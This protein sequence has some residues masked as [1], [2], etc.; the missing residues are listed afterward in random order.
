MQGIRE[1]EDILIFRVIREG[2]RQKY[3]VYLGGHHTSKNFPCNHPFF[4]SLLLEVRSE[5][6][7]CPRS[8]GRDVDTTTVP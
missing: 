7:T 2:G 8:T 5:S 4:L 1:N 3:D 6:G